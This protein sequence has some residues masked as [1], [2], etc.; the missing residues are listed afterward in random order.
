[1][2]N[3]KLP[4]VKIVGVQYPNYEVFSRSKAKIRFTPTGA[5]IEEWIK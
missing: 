3:N 2:E 4:M 5:V 1:M